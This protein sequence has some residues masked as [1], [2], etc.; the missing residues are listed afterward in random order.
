MHIET[1]DE[2]I[3]SVWLLP[4]ETV[5]VRRAQTV[6]HRSRSYDADPN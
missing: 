5:S 6:S 1:S 4:Q 3:N 2:Q